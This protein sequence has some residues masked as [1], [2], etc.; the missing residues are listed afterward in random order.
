VDHPDLPSTNIIIA[1][2][3]G[4]AHTTRFSTILAMITMSTVSAEKVSGSSIL[5]RR[6]L[7]ER[8]ADFLMRIYSFKL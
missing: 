4:N 5:S 6:K 1:K 3:P 2:Y 7:K 8:N